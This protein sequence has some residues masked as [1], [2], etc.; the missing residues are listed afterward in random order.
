MKKKITLTDRINAFMNPQPPTVKRE[1][2]ACEP[3][4][5][6]FRIVDELAK[7]GYLAF[8]KYE[9]YGSLVG[10]TLTSNE[11]EAIVFYHKDKGE[12]YGVFQRHNENNLDVLIQDL[13]KPM[14]ENRLRQLADSIDPIVAGL[15][16]YAIVDH[17]GKHEGEKMPDDETATILSRAVS[18]L[19][20]LA[21]K[22]E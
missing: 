13:T 1:V 8:V 4:H 5:A 14:K 21:A 17:T 19:R 12:L 10:I 22:G 6:V 15:H 18:E 16:K 2:P 3:S 11:K 7:V 9:L 20:K